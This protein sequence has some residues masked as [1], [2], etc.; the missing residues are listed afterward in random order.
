M[1]AITHQRA[2]NIREITRLALATYD[3]KTEEQRRKMFENYASHIARNSTIA[4]QREWITILEMTA[5][6]DGPK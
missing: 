1:T 3:A 4:E 5:P 2:E 6:K